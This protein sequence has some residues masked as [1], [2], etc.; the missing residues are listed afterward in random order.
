MMESQTA[1]AAADAAAAQAQEA[2]LDAAAERYA[3]S[4]FLY[5]HL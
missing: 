4:P 2:E 3:K 1:N 5:I